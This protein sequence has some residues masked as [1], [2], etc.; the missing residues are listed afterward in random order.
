M[1]VSSTKP[2][3]LFWLDWKVYNTDKPPSH[4]ISNLP[5]ETTYLDKNVNLKLYVSAI[6]PKSVC[7]PVQLKGSLFSTLI[8]EQQLLFILIYYWELLTVKFCNWC[9]LLLFCVKCSRRSM[10]VLCIWLHPS[11]VSSLTSAVQI[12]KL[13]QCGCHFRVL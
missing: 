5:F 9:I 7:S 12:Y 13:C 3:V 11:K 10:F 2:E 1:L 6:L 4:K 8:I